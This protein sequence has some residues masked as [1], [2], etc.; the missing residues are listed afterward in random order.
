MITDYHL[1]SPLMMTG[2]GLSVSGQH[3]L[4]REQESAAAA[5]ADPLSEYIEDSDDSDEDKD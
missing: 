1:F 4:H 5:A 3:R 2:F